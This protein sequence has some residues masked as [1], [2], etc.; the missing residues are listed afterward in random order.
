MKLSELTLNTEIGIR[1]T[2]I[3]DRE[4]LLYREHSYY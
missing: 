1:K 3:I 2:K 4:K